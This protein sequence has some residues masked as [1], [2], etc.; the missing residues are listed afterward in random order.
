MNERKPPQREGL[1]PLGAGKARS[2]EGPIAT[3]ER[4][5][6]VAPRGYLGM[7]RKE[8]SERA[9]KA[10]FAQGRDLAR[11][12]VEHREAHRDGMRAITDLAREAKAPVKVGLSKGATKRAADAR[13]RKA[14][15]KRGN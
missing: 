4:R 15:R 13:E 7:P 6:S 11:Y 10:A 3:H 1:P 2:V 5:G 12:A 8:G 9:R 14:A